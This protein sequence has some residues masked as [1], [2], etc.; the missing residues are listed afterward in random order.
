M[1]P[2]AVYLI[3]VFTSDVD[4]AASLA[5]NVVKFFLLFRILVNAFRNTCALTLGTCRYL[6]YITD[7]STGTYL[8]IF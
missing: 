1:G 6:N 8:F 2:P 3:Y 7:V 5:E 4:F